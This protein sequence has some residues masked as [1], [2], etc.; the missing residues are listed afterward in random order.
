MG[1]NLSK[2]GVQ[3]EI[4]ENLNLG[5]SEYFRSKVASSFLINRRKGVVPKIP[6]SPWLCIS[7]VLG[8]KIY[9]RKE[10][11]SRGASV[12][13]PKRFVSNSVKV[14]RRSSSIL[15]S[16]IVI[17]RVSFRIRD[18]Q[19][20]SCFVSFHLY[21]VHFWFSFLSCFSFHNLREL[22]SSKILD[23]GSLWLVP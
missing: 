14:F 15:C 18:F 11:Q 1:V 20:I 5:L 22:K 7:A 23:K 2:W 12:T 3:I 9:F 6:G 17:Q 4:F 8:E 10:N 19:F 21:F 16:F 13:L